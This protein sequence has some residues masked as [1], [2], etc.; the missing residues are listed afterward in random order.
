MGVSFW[1]KTKH[2][3]MTGMKIY[4]RLLGILM[5][6]AEFFLISEEVHRNVTTKRYGTRGSSPKY[7][8]RLLKYDSPRSTYIDLDAP[9]PST[10]RYRDYYMV[11][12]DIP[13]LACISCLAISSKVFL[14]KINVLSLKPP[15]WKETSAFQRAQKIPF[16]LWANSSVLS[17]RWREKAS[18]FWPKTQPKLF[19]PTC[20]LWKGKYHSVTLGSRVMVTPTLASETQR[21]PWSPERGW[22]HHNMKGISPRAMIPR[23]HEK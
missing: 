18:N 21:S 15:F 12:W 7:Q 11:G 9:A 23:N 1:W 19:P 5:N 6:W 3:P 2:C 20:Q 4:H 22:N 13:K 8:P 14:P 10:S 17:T 16:F